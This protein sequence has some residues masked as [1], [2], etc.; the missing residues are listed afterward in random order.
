MYSPILRALH[1]SKVGAHLGQAKAVDRAKRCSFYWPGMVAYA[2]QWVKDCWM[3]S[4]RKS[5]KHRKQALL[6]NY[7]VGATAAYYSCDF[8]DP[9]SPPTKPGKWWIFTIIMDWFTRY[10]KVYSLR[11]ATV[12]EMAQCVL[13][14][15]CTFGMPLELYS[16][17]AKNINGTVMTCLC[18]RTYNVF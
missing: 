3:C 7:R 1:D 9:F 18:K 16:D 8:C 2:I 11:H 12:E 13:D 15:V 6:L 17:N 4:R 10:N 5:P 14:F